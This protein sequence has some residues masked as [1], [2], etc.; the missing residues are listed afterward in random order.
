[1]KRPGAVHQQP[2][3]LLTQTVLQDLVAELW[4]AVARIFLVQVRSA[5]HVSVLDLWPLLVVGLI[6]LFGTDC[7]V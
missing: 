3:L 6:F 4:P 5:A 7:F 2:D 1:M